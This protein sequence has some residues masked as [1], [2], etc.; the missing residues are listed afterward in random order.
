RTFIGTQV[1]GVDP[2]SGV[3]HS[4]AFEADGGFGEADWHRD[5]DHWV[6]DATGILSDGGVLK[7]TNILRRVDDDKFTWQ[8][9]NRTLDDSEIADLPPTKV[10]RVKNGK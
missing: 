8:S 1:I 4:W 10:T 5:G 9:V 6:L 2:R 7:Q 3:V